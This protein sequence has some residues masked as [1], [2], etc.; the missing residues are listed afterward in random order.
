MQAQGAQS[1]AAL[2][3]TSNNVGG[4]VSVMSGASGYSVMSSM[5]NKNQAAGVGQQ[6]IPV[7]GGS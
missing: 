2:Q 1:T 6:R 5:L 7:I 4:G 3:Q